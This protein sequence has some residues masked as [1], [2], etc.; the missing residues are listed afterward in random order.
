MNDI[1]KSLTLEEVNEILSEAL[2]QVAARKISPKRAQIISR[3]ALALS[4]NIS[5]LELKQRIDVLEQL[6]SERR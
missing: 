1:K 2:L 4:K 3:L 5:N 6:L